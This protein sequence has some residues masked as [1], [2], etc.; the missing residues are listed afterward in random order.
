LASA[1]VALCRRLIERLS[2]PPFCVR[3]RHG[4]SL[5]QRARIGRSDRT[6]I[7]PWLVLREGQ[8]WPECRQKD[9]GWLDAPT[10]DEKTAVDAAYCHVW[11]EHY[12]PEQQAKSQAWAR[13][14]TGP[15]QWLS[16][17]PRQ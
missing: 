14:V 11:D 9:C 3:V 7:Q 12:Y 10:N 13:R 2:P 17:Q 16:I 4:E 15:R 1:S 8:W 5:P 6:P